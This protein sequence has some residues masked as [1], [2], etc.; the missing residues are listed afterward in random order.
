MH[1]ALSRLSIVS[2]A[3]LAV[4]CATA[5][6]DYAH[7]A[8]PAYQQQPALTQSLVAGA[9]PLSDAAVQKLLASR[10]ILPAQPRLALVRLKEG[11]ED[12][13]GEV[14]DAL[15]EGLYSRAAWGEQVRSLTPLP[16]LL[17]P[18]PVS[19]DGLRKA[20]LLLQA[21]A[22]VVLKTASRGDWRHRAF[23]RNQ[24]KARATVEVLLVDVR[25]GVVPYTALVSERLET[26]KDE[27][28]YDNYELRERARRLGEEKAL[29]QVPMM[30][31][32]FLAAAKE[33][34]PPPPRAR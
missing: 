1:S 7:L 11:A 17:L 12:P 26:E 21:D 6:K 19:I 13:G 4:G 9:E 24:G 23:S 3:W 27:A 18:K 16:E 14:S 31:G 22:L 25:T 33:V 20:A 32:K 28:D 29:L 30:V 34:S 5:Q 2:L 10:V 8:T 15:A